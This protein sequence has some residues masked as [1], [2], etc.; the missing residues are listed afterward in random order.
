MQVLLKDEQIKLL[1]VIQ[2]L[3]YIILLCPLTSGGR[4]AK[5]HWVF[6]GGGMEENLHNTERVNGMSE[7][8]T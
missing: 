6:D 8:A 1:P 5:S 3:I 2:S 7:W 4:C